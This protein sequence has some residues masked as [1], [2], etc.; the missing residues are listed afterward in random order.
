MSTD[1]IAIDWS[2][3]KSGAA[4]HIWLAVVR[5]AELIRLENGR[6]GSEVIDEVIALGRRN[7]RTVI[8]LDFAFSLPTW[9]LDERGWA[10]AHDAWTTLTDEAQE[11][12]DQCPPPFWGRT[13]R[14]NLH[15]KEPARATERD[16]GFTPKSVFQ[17][18]GAGAV[19]T[20]SLRGMPQ[21]ARLVEAGF[22]IWPFDP[23]GWPRVVEIYP[24]LL[25][26]AVIK[27]QHSKRLEYL[28]ARHN[29]RPVAMIERA[30]GSEDAFDAAVSAVVMARHVIELEALEQAT[31][32][33][34]EAREGAIWRPGIAPSGTPSAASG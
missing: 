17:I 18:G 1:V 8:G 19:G 2:G 13:G 23:S 21:L 10:A 4:E 25:T 16:L 3:K 30:A 27:S 7:P 34:P 29:D 20:G 31:P 5:D 28:S 6:S 11:I 14:R 33:A 12:L 9:Y 15:G 22:S 24:R 32:D 26:E